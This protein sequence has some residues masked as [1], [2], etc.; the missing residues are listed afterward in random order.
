VSQ[1]DDLDRKIVEVLRRDGRIPFRV[2]GDEIGLS[3]N[4]T[5]DRVRGLLRRGVITGFTAIVDDSATARSLEAVVDL[6]LA[7]EEQR[8]SFEEALRELPAIVGA[9]HLTGP[10]D[11]QLRLACGE[12]TE[13]DATIAKL[14]RRRFV[15]DT[16]TRIVL[17]QVV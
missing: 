7:H 3:A 13:I 16:Q 14:K 1:L 8:A 12:A 6:R 11:Y 5:A 4:A 17:R 2:L 10:F 15:R 9:V